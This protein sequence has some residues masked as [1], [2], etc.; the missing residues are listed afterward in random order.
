LIDGTHI[1]F[2]TGY[3]SSSAGQKERRLDAGV[4]QQ[5]IADHVDHDAVK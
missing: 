2:G 5:K 3:A 4:P 1:D